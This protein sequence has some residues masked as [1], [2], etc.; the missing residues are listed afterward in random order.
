MSLNEQVAK[1]F[2]ELEAQGLAIPI[3]RAAPGEGSDSVDPETF[4]RWA[5]SAMHLVA[6][7]FGEDSPQFLLT[8]F[9]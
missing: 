9:T 5:S 4:Q 6:S 7:V 3:K 1:R 8:K 2:A